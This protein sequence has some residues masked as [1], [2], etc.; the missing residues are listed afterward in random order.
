M[1]DRYIITVS[2]SATPTDY[3][4]PI[5]IG[6][7][8]TEVWPSN[9]YDHNYHIGQNGTIV[10]SV[11][12]TNFV[13]AN[14]AP[15][16]LYFY[17]DS[18]N[19]SITLTHVKIEVVR[20]GQTPPPT[21]TTTSSGGGDGRP[22]GS[23]DFVYVG[24]T[25]YITF[26]SYGAAGTLGTWWWYTSDATNTTKC[27]TYLNFLYMNGVDE[28]YF[29]GYYWSS[30]NKPALHSFVQKANAQGM[31]VSLIYDDADTIT[32]NGNNEM[33]HIT[34]HYLNYCSTYPT[35]QMAGIHFDVEGVS[36]ENMVNNMIS[37]FAAARAQGVYI[38]MDVNCGWSCTST[39]NGISGF[40]NIASANLDCL[41]LMSYRDTA[42]AIW[43]L[44]A[45]PLAAAKTYGT[46]IVFGVETGHFSFN[47]GNVE[48]YQ[49]GKE[50]CY[51][52]LAKVYNWLVADHP[53]GGYG[54][55]VHDVDWWYKLKNKIT[56][57]YPA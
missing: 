16:V 36:R 8:S 23:G 9:A 46:K 4:Y 34:T 28:I 21:T 19:A 48:F 22:T 18:E 10:G 56:D 14:D 38:T 39:L 40:M 49:E 35:D 47:S 26:R 17:A 42:T 25:P 20:S 37:Q 24:D 51:T 43:T 12:G 11:L 13:N 41:S 15:A 29:Y 5:L 2:A 52:E 7:S 6:A 53:T 31:K 27:D 50:I 30:S 54:I 44:G 45:N 3:I 1:A 32:A 57:P 33:S 55:A